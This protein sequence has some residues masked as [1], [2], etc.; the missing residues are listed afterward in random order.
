MTFS[1]RHTLHTVLFILGIV[2]VSLWYQY[3]EVYEYGPMSL[4]RWRQADGASIALNYY[5][6]GMHFFQP[7][8]HHMLNGDP[9]AVSEFPLM[10]YL[11]AVL[12][13][14]FGPEEG[15]FRLLNFLVLAVGLFLVS[16]LLLELT[17]QLV[18]SL[19]MPLLLLGSPIVAFYGFNFLPNTVGLGFSLGAFYFYYRALREEG[20]KW[21]ALAILFFLL[22]AL[23]KITTLIPFVALLG[24]ALVSYALPGWRKNASTYFLTPGRLLAMAVIVVG[25]T[26]AWYLW[27]KHYNQAHQSGLLTTNFKPI[28]VMSK[29][30]IL[31][32]YNDIRRWYHALYFHPYTLV[33]FGGLL[34]AN[35]FLF[36]RIPR[37]IYLFYV[38]NILGCIAFLV[39]FYAQILVH[40]YYI[41][42]IMSIFLLTFT[43]FFW[44]I[45][46]GLSRKP[47]QWAF[48][49]FLTGFVLFNWQDARQHHM[50]PYYRPDHPSISAVNPAFFQRAEL[51]AFLEEKG[52]EFDQDRVV[53]A[54]DVTPNVTLYYLNLRGWSEFGA[55]PLTDERIGQ[56]IQQGA[57]YLVLADT[58][59]IAKLPVSTQKPVGVF[60]GEIYF[61]DL[62]G[63]GR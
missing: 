33:A 7:R 10:Y 40:H 45:G 44:V 21:Y 3:P 49:L 60:A 8:V 31:T 63:L 59:Y 20:W 51:R 2:L 50:I 4:H 32:T 54:P 28:W 41:I 55:Q 57:D 23:I 62:I 24:V 30:S 37:E 29:E 39:L 48:S 11:A 43:L 56:F 34:I 13:H 19:T 58:S 16:R 26:A 5:Q 14:L 36:R 47:S 53:T 22:G 6:E 17:G 25:L 1:Y 46:R 38:F 18:L 9:A 15:L 52:L 12:Y 35:L 61:Y 42:D 27:A